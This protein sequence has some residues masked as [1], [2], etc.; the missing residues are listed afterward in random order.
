MASTHESG[1]TQPHRRL[2]E[3]L[4]LAAVDMFTARTILSE[5]RLAAND[6]AARVQWAEMVLAVV[7]NAAPSDLGAARAMLYDVRVLARDHPDEPRLARLWAEAAAEIID[8]IASSD[9][10][11]ARGLLHEMQSAA[12]ELSSQAL[13]QIWQETGRALANRTAHMDRIAAD[14]IRREIGQDESLR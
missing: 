14:A 10:A 4:H 3:V 7:K 13:V 9:L 5:T 1:G 11:S 6:A 8:A 12:H 2:G